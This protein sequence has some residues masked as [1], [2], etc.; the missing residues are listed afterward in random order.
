M[1]ARPGCGCVKPQLPQRQL[2]PGKRGIMPLE[3]K[4]LGQSAGPHTW[5]LI[6]V[7][8]DGGQLREQALQVTATVVTEVTV[9][10][11]SLMLFTEGAFSHEVI[12]TDLRKEP[13]QNL[14]VQT[15]SAF[16]RAT[17]GPF[18]RDGF[19]NSMCRIKVE[20]AGELPAGRHDEMLII[21]TSDPLYNEFT[22]PI[23]VIKQVN[24]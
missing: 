8:R 16:L 6:L 2:G 15:S 9:Q 17:A 11:A 13:L 4:T 1:E 23:T 3:L 20:T 24:R 10:P 19:G 22:I 21:H 12:L 7:Y 14:I 5:Q 18:D